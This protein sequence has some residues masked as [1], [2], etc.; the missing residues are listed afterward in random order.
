MEVRQ[1]APGDEALLAQLARDDAA[2]DLADRGEPRLPL[3]DRD[4]AAYL[5][6]PAVLHWAALDDG[7]ALGHLLC[8]VERRR[9]G[10]ARELLLYEIGVRESH[11]RRGIGTALVDAMTRWMGDHGVREVWVLADNDE[12]VAFY[13]ACGF[14]RDDVHVTQ[15][16]RRV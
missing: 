15:L 14:A 13:E 11:R 7:L 10:D 6:D 9:S 4:A 3:D 2:F 1:L 12:A 16:T 8:H 5:A